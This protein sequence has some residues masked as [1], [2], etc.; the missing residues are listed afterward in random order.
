MT[1]SLRIPHS[2]YQIPHSPSG[3]AK[4][5]RLRQK[6]RCRR[7]SFTLRLR[8]ISPAFRRLLAAGIVLRA[9][10][11]FGAFAAAAAASA[12]PYRYRGRPADQQNEQ[13]RQ[14][15]V[16]CAHNPPP[17]SSPIRCRSSAAIHAMPHCAATTNAAHF[18][19]SSRRIAAIAATQGV[20]SSEK[21]SRQPAES[22][23]IAPATPPP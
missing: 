4:K 15:D 3:Y 8:Q 16:R 10:A 14:D 9:F 1:E 7:S 22:V 21:T 19:P 13:H 17:V 12:L 23:L 2:K 18:L 5:G 20:Y 11:A 6:T